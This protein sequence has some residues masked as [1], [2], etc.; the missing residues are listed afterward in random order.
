MAIEAKHI[1]TP[2]GVNAEQQY[3]LH[4]QNVIHVHDIYKLVEAHNEYVDLFARHK[5]EAVEGW[6]CRIL[7]TRPKR[8]LQQKVGISI[9]NKDSGFVRTVDIAF[10]DIPCRIDKLY[11]D[12]VQRDR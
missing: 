12:S 3:L 7:F 11:Y 2:Y 1:T 8:G 5:I 9:H 6:G 10:V 4:L